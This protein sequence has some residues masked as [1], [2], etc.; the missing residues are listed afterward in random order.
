MGGNQ[1][2]RSSFLTLPR[3]VATCILAERTVEEA[4]ATIRNGEYD[5]APAFA[6]HLEPLGPGQ[7]TENTFRRIADSTH[8]PIMFLHYRGNI[9]WPSPLGDD[10]RAEVLK[11]AIRCG[12][13]A[14]DIT[15]DMFDASPYEF[16]ADS[17]AID[18]QRRF[19]EDVHE[20][21]GEVVMSSHIAEAR[22]C[23]QVLE[24]MKAVEARGA[25]FA[26]IVTLADTK[27]QFLEAIKTTLALREEMSVPF[28]H[29]CGG[30]FARPLRYLGP[31]LGCA[32]TFCVQKYS[33]TFTTVQPPLHN[34]LSILHN[35]QWHIDDTEE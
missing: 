6:I 11:S 32:L 23:E 26:K 33:A 16:S 35:Y 18:R 8:K 19:I 27:A 2:K 30:K 13:T 28:I 12:A 20:M 25:D 9:H 22:T 17:K 1:M 24:H 4:V 21:G 7:L 29:L 31:S 5:G 3:P 10:E 15:A 34:M 14:T